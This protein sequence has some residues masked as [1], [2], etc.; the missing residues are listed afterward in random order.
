MPAHT[1]I[2]ISHWSV[3]ILI[4]MMAAL[5][6]PDDRSLML[7]LY[8]DHYSLVRKVIY[9]I[10]R[11]ASSVEDLINDTYIK[12]IRNI[13]TLRTLNCCKTV[14]YLVYTARSVAIN[15]IIR[16]DVQNKHGYY[17]EDADLAEKITDLAATVEETVIRQVGVDEMYKVLL[18]LPE[19]H[20][21]ILYFKYILEMDDA[22]IADTLQIT[23]ASVRQYLTRARRAARQGMQEVNRHE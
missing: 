23:P 21:D 9:G 15:F 13:S 18:S 7:G 16:R 17:G 19:K 10:T 22:E 3:I 14:A 11:D 2:F 1:G 8:Q 20:K 5:T 12:L 4:V 6:C